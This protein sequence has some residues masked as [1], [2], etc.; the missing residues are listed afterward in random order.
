MMGKGAGH[1]AVRRELC[2]SRSFGIARFYGH[3]QPITRG[4]QSLS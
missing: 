4:P 3:D 1:D 2:Q